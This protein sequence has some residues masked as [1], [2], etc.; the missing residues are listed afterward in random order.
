[1]EKIKHEVY[2]GTHG[3]H[4]NKEHKGAC[5]CHCKI[6]LSLNWDIY[7]DDIKTAIRINANGTKKLLL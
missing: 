3:C 4:K 1:M 6:W 7:G 2:W 5:R